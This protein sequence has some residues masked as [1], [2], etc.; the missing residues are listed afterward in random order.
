MKKDP[1]SII[2]EAAEAAGVSLD[3]LDAGVEV[4]ADGIGNR[5]N[6]VGEETGQILVKGFGNGLHLGDTA[7]HRGSLPSGEEVQAL[8]GVRLSPELD[9]L[10]FVG[11]C[12]GGLQVD[13]QEFGEA[14][15]LGFGQPTVQPNVAS[16]FEGV[17]AR[18]LESLMFGPPG[19]VDRVVE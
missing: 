9:K 6:E 10:F 17:V 12:F 19:P 14:L 16:V 15:L 3:G 8:D 13:L 1:G 7:T 5:M 11:P 4:L 18:S 2:G